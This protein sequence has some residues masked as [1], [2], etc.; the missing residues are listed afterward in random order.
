MAN[1]SLSRPKEAWTRPATRVRV[2][3]ARP[4]PPQSPV[5]TWAGRLRQQREAEL[6]RGKAEQKHHASWQLLK[7]AFDAVFDDGA[8]AVD[9]IGMASL[10]EL[11][12]IPIQPERVP[13][14]MHQ[15]GADRG[16]HVGFDGFAAWYARA[17]KQ[18][19]VE[20]L[21]RVREA[22]DDADRDGSGAL[23]KGEVAALSRRLGLRLKTLYSSKN[24]DAA[25]S[26]MDPNGD[27]C[28]DFEEFRS[29]WMKRFEQQKTEQAVTLGDKV[30]NMRAASAARRESE[31]N[32]ST[33][34]NV[35]A[36]ASRAK[37]CN[38][39]RAKWKDFSLTACV[40]CNRSSF[41]SETVELMCVLHR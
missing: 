7:D 34:S 36:Q 5:P 19:K 40:S 25:W 26:E 27:G 32:R 4:T 22:F 23:D 29:W 3:V 6:R 14:A 30:A 20:E 18:R 17:E 13:A 37:R 33:D 2:A 12:E 28:V 24:L 1:A 16:G 35:R 39:V 38:W 41:Y 15:M 10:L 21:E 11:L 8:R 9:E 31:S